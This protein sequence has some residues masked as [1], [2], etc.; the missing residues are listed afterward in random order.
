MIDGECDDRPDFDAL[1]AQGPA[2]D[3]LVTDDYLTFYRYGFSHC[4]PVVEVD[5]IDD[6]PAAVKEYMDR[7][8]FWPNV[9]LARE[10]GGWDLLDARTM[11]FA[12]E[13]RP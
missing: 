12:E 2:D 10:R 3:D 4:G 8:Q 9:W 6:A 5:E 11:R 1:D 13:A 7:E